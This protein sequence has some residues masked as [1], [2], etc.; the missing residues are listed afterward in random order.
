MLIKKYDGNN[1]IEKRVNDKDYDSENTLLNL[2]R[3]YCIEAARNISY[4]FPGV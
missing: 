2:F 1:Y 3:K 4:Y